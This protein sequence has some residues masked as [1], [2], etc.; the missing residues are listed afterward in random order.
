MTE[1]MAF[2]NH[3]VKDEDY[4]TGLRI[5]KA[6]QTGAKKV[7]IFGKNEGGG[8]RFHRFVDALLEVEDEDLAAFFKEAAENWE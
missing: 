2:L 5:Q 6:L 4:Y 3:V 1:V 8:Q 7:N